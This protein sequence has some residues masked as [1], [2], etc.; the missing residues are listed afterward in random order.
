MDFLPPTGPDPLTDPRSG[1][2]DPYGLPKTREGLERAYVGTLMR[3]RPS[4]AQPTVRVPDG[5]LSAVREAIRAELRRCY[6]YGGAG[7]IAERIL[8]GLYRTYPPNKACGEVVQCAVEGRE[9][10]LLDVI[11]ERLLSLGP[12]DGAPARQ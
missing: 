9:P 4:H 7:E 3:L 2:A 12:V 11:A 5:A 10:G 1:P 8:P 6:P